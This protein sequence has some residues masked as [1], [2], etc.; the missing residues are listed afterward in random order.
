MPRNVEIKARISDAEA[1]AE[2][3]GELSE[4]LGVRLVQSDTFFRCDGARLK[5]RV[6]EGAPEGE[7]IH[8]SRPDHRGPKT[9]TFTR[10]P[11]SVPE[12]LEAVL[13]AAYGIL[14]RVRK[15]RR[16]FIAGRTR[17]HI[18]EVDGLG[19]FLELEVCMA[20]DEPAEAGEKESRDLMAK[21]GVTEDQLVDTAY[22]DLILNKNTTTGHPLPSTQSSPNVIPT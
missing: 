20:D 11:V 2:I 15:T 10:T 21:L 5:L 16:L 3:A 1:S 17:I 18:D 13:G 7:L 14:G 9:S 22:M 6:I 19:S 4:S 12:E 8:Y